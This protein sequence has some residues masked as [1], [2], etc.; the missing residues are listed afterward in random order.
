MRQPTMRRH[1]AARDKARWLGRISRPSILAIIRPR[2]VNDE[3][4]PRGAHHRAS[5]DIDVRHLAMPDVVLFVPAVMSI[6]LSGLLH[7]P[8]VCGLGT[9]VL[10]PLAR[11]RGWR[12][13]R[14]CCVHRRDGM[15]GRS[16][17][18]QPGYGVLPMVQ[19]VQTWVIV[20]P[21]PTIEWPQSADPGMS[22]FP[23]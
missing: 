21:D 23:S 8:E 10:I 19:R 7:L 13:T 17:A 3:P 12:D 9:S 5:I 20:V 4:G 16:M 11:N 1:S 14:Y 15:A 2:P 22:D 18:I 6:R